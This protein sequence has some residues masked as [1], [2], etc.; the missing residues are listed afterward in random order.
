MGEINWDTHEENLN[1]L[2]SRI[3]RGEFG[4]ADTA[5]KFIQE[6]RV[7]EVHP[8]MQWFED[9]ANTIRETKHSGYSYWEQT[10]RAF[11]QVRST[12]RRIAGHDIRNF[13]DLEDEMRRAEKRG[14]RRKARALGN[15]VSR[16][17][18]IR[19][20]YRNTMRRVNPEL[21][22]ALRE[23]GYVTAKPSAGAKI[24]LPSAFE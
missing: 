17:N 18:S 2:M 14:D 22:K 16:V 12:A 6:R 5:R 15:L 19:R 10:N 23:N 1:N 8:D 4:D 9:N 11:E 21:D 24:S 3:D 20:G 13:S 7:A